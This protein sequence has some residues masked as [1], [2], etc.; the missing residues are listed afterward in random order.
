MIFAFFP[1]TKTEIPNDELPP[2]N[3]KGNVSEINPDKISTKYI[4]DNNY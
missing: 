3:L 4:D 1:F 2:V